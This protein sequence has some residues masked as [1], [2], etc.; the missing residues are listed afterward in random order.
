MARVHVG[1]ELQLFFATMIPASVDTSNAINWLGRRDL[2]LTVLD[3]SPV[4]FKGPR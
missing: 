1:C 2:H 3:A 4:M